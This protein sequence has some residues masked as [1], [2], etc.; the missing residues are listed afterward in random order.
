[1]SDAMQVAIGLVILVPFIMA[2]ALEE[3]CRWWEE[4]ER[5]KR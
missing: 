4:R 1:M 2:V 5:R 3:T